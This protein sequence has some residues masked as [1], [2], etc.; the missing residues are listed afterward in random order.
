MARTLWSMFSAKEKVCW[1]LH[2]IINRMCWRVKWRNPYLKW[3]NDCF[4]DVWLSKYGEWRRLWI[5]ETEEETGSGRR[6]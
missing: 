6:I 3:L 5:D 2:G 4:A 1:H